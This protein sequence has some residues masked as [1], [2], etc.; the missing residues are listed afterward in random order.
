MAKWMRTWFLWKLLVTL[1]LIDDCF[2]APLGTNLTPTTYDQGS[3]TSD[4]ASDIVESTTTTRLAA[5]S[6][7]E[8]LSV[9]NLG[10]TTNNSKMVEPTTKRVVSFSILG[11]PL[12]CPPGYIADRGRNICVR[13]IELDREYLY[14][15]LYTLI[16]HN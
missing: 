4:F 3:L 5:F 2:S 8:N 1:F 11:K 14:I 13:L 10:P 9:T 15:F 7:F 12:D 16:N 6:I